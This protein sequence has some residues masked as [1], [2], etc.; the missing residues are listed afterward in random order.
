MLSWPT[1][2]LDGT[3][4]L[5]LLIEFLRA[6]PILAGLQIHHPNREIFALISAAFAEVSLPTVSALSVHEE[7]YTILPAFP[8]LRTLVFSF[9]TVSESSEALVAVKA[10]FLKLEAVVG[11]RLSRGDET[12]IGAHVEHLCKYRSHHP[13]ALA[14][15]FPCLR[16]LS[17]ASPFLLAFEVCCFACR[18]SRPPLLMHTRCSPF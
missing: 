11:L 1:F 3:E 4:T 7:L 17:I 6:P 16:A 10:H 5:L 2:F 9:A 13:A 14:K 8:N 18:V 15:D 12:Y